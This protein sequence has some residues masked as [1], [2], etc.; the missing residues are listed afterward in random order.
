[1]IHLTGVSTQSCTQ[2]AHALTVPGAPS[3]ADCIIVESFDGVAGAITGHGT[4]Y[5]NKGTYLRAIMN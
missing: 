3:L 4:Q 2:V 5:S 1:M